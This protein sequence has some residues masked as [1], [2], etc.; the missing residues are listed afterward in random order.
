[1]ARPLKPRRICFCPD[2]YYFK[3]RG[4][5]LVE[6][7]ETNLL[8]EELEALK[9]CDAENI[10]QIKA[11][12]KMKISQSTLSRILLSARKKVACAIIEGKAIRLGKK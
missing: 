1:M 7:E 10:E 2:V 9:L 3:P 12:K 11:A 6:L 4:V 5:P 8:P